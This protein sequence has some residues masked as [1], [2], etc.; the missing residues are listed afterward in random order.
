MPEW[1][2]WET[3]LEDLAEVRS[4][5]DYPQAWVRDF[6]GG[7][8]FYTSLGYRDDIWS[9]DPVFEAHVA[10]GIRWALGLEPGDATPEDIQ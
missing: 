1:L 5:G 4:G 2:K 9:N 7:R 6:G 10:G 3:R 8:S